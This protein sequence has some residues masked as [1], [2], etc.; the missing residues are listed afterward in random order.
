MIAVLG[1]IWAYFH[2]A[3]DSIFLTPRNLSNLMT[4]MSVTGILS[5]GQQSEE[6]GTPSLFRLSLI[7]PA[8]R[9]VAAKRPK[10]ATKPKTVK[11]SAVPKP[12]SSLARVKAS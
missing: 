4:Q 10:A 9:P 7:P 5:V 12:R 8:V 3:T 2:W 6:G 11:P 1:L